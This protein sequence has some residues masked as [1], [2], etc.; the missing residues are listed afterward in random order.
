MPCSL[1]TRPG[2]ASGAAESS[3][4]SSGCEKASAPESNAS[5][6]NAAISRRRL[7]GSGFI[8]AS[9]SKLERTPEPVLRLDPIAPHCP[10]GH[11][12]RRGR[13]LFAQV[14]E[15]AALHYLGQSLVDD[16]QS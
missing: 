5:S 1:R 10:R 16:G 2:I 13:L 3:A 9:S 14:A 11:A 12:E 7:L 8:R 4:S 6:N 15:E